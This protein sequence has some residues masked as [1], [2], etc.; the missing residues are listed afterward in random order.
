MPTRGGDRGRERW[1]ERGAGFGIGILRRL[2][3]KK[4][5]NEKPRSVVGGC[6]HERRVGII[7]KRLLWGDRDGAKKNKKKNRVFPPSIY[8]HI[9]F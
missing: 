5:K 8:L 2:R 4:K 6:F 9:F 1:G 7:P 3:R